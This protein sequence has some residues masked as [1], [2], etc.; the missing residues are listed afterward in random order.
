MKNL[1]G[2]QDADKSILEELYLA[3]IESVKVDT[4]KGDVPFT[5]VGKIGKWKLERRWYYWS[6]F[7][8]DV[9]DGV[10]LQP[11]LEFNNR[12]RPTDDTVIL[13][14]TVRAGGH[15]GGISPDDYVGKTDRAELVSECKRIGLSTTSAKAMGWSEDETEYSNLNYGEISKLCN[16][17]KI[18]CK[19]YIDVYHIDD[20]IGLNEF[21]K[22][23]KSLEK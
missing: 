21:A 22:F 23:I 9:K 20:Q 10:P 18:N 12:K 5:F 11:A 2:V 7:V 6:A 15:G 16:E 17:G 4:S 8:D 3:G 19:R 14:D 1:A 13:G